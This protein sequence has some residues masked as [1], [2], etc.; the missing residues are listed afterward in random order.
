MSPITKKLDAMLKADGFSML[1]IGR[2]D[3]S[4]FSRDT[5]VNQLEYIRGESERVYITTHEKAGETA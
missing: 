4:G 1:D 3:N 2:I 5:N